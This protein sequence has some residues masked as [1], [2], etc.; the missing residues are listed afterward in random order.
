MSLRHAASR[1]PARP[2][3]LVAALLALGAAS[4]LQAAPS[5]NPVSGVAASGPAPAASTTAPP[6]AAASSG[7]VV[8]APDAA[9]ARRL[10]PADGQ[11]QC[12]AAVGRAIRDARGKAV[13][14]AITFAGDGKAARNDGGQMEVQGA[15]KYVR[16]GGAAVSF[17]YRCILDDAGGEPGVMFHEADG[18]PPPPLHVWQADITKVSPGACEGAVAGSL[19]QRFPRASGVAF[20]GATRRLDPAVDGGTALSGQGRWMRAPGLPVATFRYRCVFDAAGRLGEV[21]AD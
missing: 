3:L 16:G 12:E 11:A 15:G 9:R 13:Q 1:V 19:Q 14:G 2:A 18:A 7:V 10:E 20:D 6:D 5:A 4:G 8:S 21:K 17:R